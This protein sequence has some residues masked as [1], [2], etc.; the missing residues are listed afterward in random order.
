MV[1]IFWINYIEI[2]AFDYRSYFLANIFSGNLNN[3][4][5]YSK[6]EILDNRSSM[7]ILIFLFY[8]VYKCLKSINTQ[9]DHTSLIKSKNLKCS[10]TI[11]QLLNVLVIRFTSWTVYQN[12]NLALL[13]L[14]F[15]SLS[16]RFI[17]DRL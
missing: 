14:I 7:P 11:R 15:E 13:S 17:F 8:I 12:N 5:A 2:L 6:E 10:I 1:Y 3:C 9:S 4:F 16:N